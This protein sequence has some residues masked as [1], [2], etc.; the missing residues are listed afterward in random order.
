MQYMQQRS[1]DISHA[2]GVLIVVRVYNRTGPVNEM[3]TSYRR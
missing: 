2:P 3:V 1:V